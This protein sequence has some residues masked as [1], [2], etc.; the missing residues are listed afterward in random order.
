MTDLYLECFLNQKLTLLDML[1][2]LMLCWKAKAKEEFSFAPFGTL[3]LTPELNQI[4][5]NF[6]PA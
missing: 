1:F 6:E 2:S 5:L 4:S 3:P